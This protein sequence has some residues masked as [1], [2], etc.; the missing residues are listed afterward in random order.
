MTWKLEVSVT[1]VKLTKLYTSYICENTV[2]TIHVL[3]GFPPSPCHKKNHLI[4]ITHKTTQKFPLSAFSTTTTTTTTW[5]LLLTTG[6][7]DD[8]HTHSSHHSLVYSPPTLILRLFPLSS[9]LGQGL[10][11]SSWAQQLL[12]FYSLDMYVYSHQFVTVKA[13]CCQHRFQSFWGDSTA[14]FFRFPQGVDK[15]VFKQR[16]SGS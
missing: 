9:A 5:P 8:T 12:K 4:N 13:E 6:K 10:L 11:L 2:P 15:Q 16:V 3:E 1:R 14:T 7:S